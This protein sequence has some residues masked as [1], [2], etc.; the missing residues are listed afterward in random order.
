M[1]L[2]LAAWIALATAYFL[3]FPITAATDDWGSL[4]IVAVCWIGA[5]TATVMASVRWITRRAY[6]QAAAVAV[7][8]IAAAVGIWRADWPTMYI[9]SQFSLHR[10]ALHDLATAYAAG[11]VASSERLPLTIRYLSR[12]GRAHLQHGPDV[13]YL[14]MWENW[15]GEAGAG[16]AYLG[17]HPP[18]DVLVVTAPGGLGKPVRY[19]G[20]GWWWVA[21][22]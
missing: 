3:A 11:E 14:P 6:A 19:L 15:R 17:E 9:D 16:M 13:L 1:L 2:A 21:G 10:A 12:D 8:S 7:L 4:A 20:D 22:D 5:V 18:A